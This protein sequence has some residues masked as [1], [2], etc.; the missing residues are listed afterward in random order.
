MRTAFEQVHGFI[1]LCSPLNLNVATN[2]FWLLYFRLPHSYRSAGHRVS[3]PATRD[4]YAAAASS[5]FRF[6]SPRRRAT[7][8][9]NK[10]IS[11][12]APFIHSAESNSRSQAQWQKETGEKRNVFEIIHCFTEWDAARGLD[13]VRARFVAA[14]QGAQPRGDPANCGFSFYWRI[15]LSAPV[16]PARD[17]KHVNCWTALKH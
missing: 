13:V 4:A 2:V 16:H 12:F 7:N 15:L 8:K 3:F 1:S 10:L 5:L 17:G 6:R 11:M 9:L 14:R